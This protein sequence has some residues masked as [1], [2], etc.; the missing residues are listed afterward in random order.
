MTGLNTPKTGG[1]PPPRQP[2]SA[3]DHRDLMSAFPTGVTVVTA[4]DPAGNPCG[5]TCSSMA[6]VTL[7]PPTLLVCLGIGGLTCDAALSGGAFA[8]NLL[9][10]RARRAAELFCAPVAD[11]FDQIHWRHSPAGYP[12]LIDDAFALAE[13]RI[14]HSVDIGDHTVVFGQVQHVIRATGI[15]LLYGMRRFSSWDPANHHDHPVPSA[16]TLNNDSSF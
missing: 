16:C 8:V 7:S 10:A 11:R 1:R 5:M 15:P 3:D 2:A 13:C 12:W 14:S 6:S 9:H 4:L